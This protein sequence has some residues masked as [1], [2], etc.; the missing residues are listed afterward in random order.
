M[1]QILWSEA[2][3]VPEPSA[4]RHVPRLISRQRQV[5][6]GEHGSLSSNTPTPHP[7][8]R[9]HITS[10]PSQPQ[11]NER[12]SFRP[13]VPQPETGPSTLSRLSKLK[14]KE[15]G[16]LRP[17]HAFV[18]GTNRGSTSEMS[19][20]HGKQRERES[21]RKFRPKQV[22]VDLYIPSTVTVGQLAKLLNVRL[23][24]ANPFS[25]AQRTDSVLFEGT[26]Q[27]KMD[28]VGMYEASSYDYGRQLSL[29]Q[30]ER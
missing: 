1:R 19:R 21:G 17:G 27:R 2:D 15:H 24:M 3:R 9:S 6:P 8:S 16:F 7:Q 4:S 22:Q 23:R 18:A 14:S 13:L 25:G 12:S 10:R 28:Q 30:S 26:L 20:W 29:S 11:L 5:K